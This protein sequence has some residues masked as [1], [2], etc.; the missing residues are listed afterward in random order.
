M[1]GDQYQ[2]GD[3]V[4]VCR[5]IGKAQTATVVEKGKGHAFVQ[6]DKGKEPFY[7]HNRDIKSVVN[8][9]KE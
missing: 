7:V 2:A 4:K 1:K 8:G 5:R 3:K 6:T 9:R